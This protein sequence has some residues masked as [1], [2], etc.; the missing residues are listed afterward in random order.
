MAGLFAQMLMGGVQQGAQTLG[1]Q[2]RERAQFNRQKALEDHR[3]RRQAQ[4]RGMEQR[5]MAGE[6]QKQRDFQAEQNELN[7]PQYQDVKN[8]QGMLVGQRETKSNRYHG[9]GSKSGKPDHTHLKLTVDD[10]TNQRDHQYEIYTSDTTSQSDKD[11]ALKQINALNTQI[12]NAIQGRAN[13]FRRYSQEEVNK[14]LDEKDP[15]DW[16]KL[17]ED[18]RK[19]ADSSSYQLLASAMKEREAKL[20][21]GVDQQ[22]GQG[23]E[24]LSGLFSSDDENN[25]S[26]DT[27]TKSGSSANNSLFGQVPSSGPGILGASASSKE[28][29]HSQARQSEIEFAMKDA[30]KALTYSPVGTGGRS[31]RGKSNDSRQRDYKARRVEKLLT[32]KQYPEYSQLPPDQ[33]QRIES[34]IAQLQQH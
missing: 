12:N 6:S 4:A 17:L 2:A 28:Q 32:I 8:D 13:T 29:R 22:D 18:T 9:F 19:V 21:S 34:L 15:K 10:L 26:K 30:E 31:G 3:F 23:K 1:R 27:E 33:Q 14:M 25:A 20:K 5:F 7:R 11:A 24:W 16:A